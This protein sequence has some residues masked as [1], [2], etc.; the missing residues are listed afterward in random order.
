MNFCRGNAAAELEH[1]AAASHPLLVLDPPVT[2]P[3]I[4]GNKVLD[5]TKFGVGRTWDIQMKLK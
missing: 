4:N 5:L 1:G 2:V 3:V